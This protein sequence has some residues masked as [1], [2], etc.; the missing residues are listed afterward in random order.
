[1][2]IW[3]S[4]EQVMGHGAK[5]SLNFLSPDCVR[6]YNKSCRH[7]NLSAGY[8]LM[9]KARHIYVGIIFILAVTAAETRAVHLR[10]QILHVGFP[11]SG[12]NVNFTGADHHRL[13]CWTPILVELTNDEGDLFG[14]RI[15]VRQIDRDGDEIFDQRDVAVRGTKN[16]Y[17]YVPAG[18]LKDKNQ[19]CVRVFNSDGSLAELNN[20]RNEKVKELLPRRGINAVPEEAITILDISAQPINQLDKLVNDERLAQELIVAR[21][22]P[23]NVP[24][25]VAGLEMADIIIWD[26]ADPNSI[27]LHQQEALIEW[28]GRGG[29]LVVGVGKNWQVVNKSQIGK[30]LPAKLKE[31]VSTTKLR[32][33]ADTLFDYTDTDFDPPELETPLT[34]CPVTLETLTDDSESIIPSTPTMTDRLFVTGRPCGQGRVIMV[35]AELKDLFK[36]GT[37][38]QKFIRHILGLRLQSGAAEEGYGYNSVDLFRFIEGKIGF[39]VTAT[40]YLLIAFIFVSAYILI[41]TAGSW[42][43][44]K[45]KKLIQHNW[46]AFT[47]AAILASAFSLMAVQFIRGYG[48]RV[49]E[50]TIVDSR[51]GSY[52]ASATCYLGLKT[53]S[54]TLLD[55]RVPGNWTKSAE[56]DELIANLRPLAPISSLFETRTYVV[57]KQYESV[58]AL[59]E[60]RTVPIRAT[61]KQFEAH[62]HGEMNH[63][64]D[65]SLRRVRSD[66][67][68]L[69]GNSWIRNNLNTDLENCYLIVPGPNIKPNSPLRS[70]QMR[71]YK[72]GNIPNGAKLDLQTIIDKEISLNENWRPPFLGDSQKTWLAKF[73]HI[74]PQDRPRSE[75][76]SIRVKIEDVASALLLLT[77]FDTVDQSNQRTRGQEVGR[78][79]GHRLDRSSHLTKHTALFVGFSRDPSPARL[80]WRKPR[81]TSGGW[82]AI[83]PDESYVMYRIEMPIAGN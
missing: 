22:R 62:W 12:H 16:Y 15:E 42:T 75:D 43:L 20:D 4:S 82:K 70:N 14:G 6:V 56:S 53:G 31:A 29:T 68:Y 8:G 44:L 76:K 80:C 38:N 61:L 28:T 17:L 41:A 72:L 32:E 78:S 45:K 1:M 26:A 47:I 33:L 48:R 3:G 71:I 9:P 13:G 35:A 46:S 55:L 19:Y 74:R 81:K 5:P 64:C 7:D 77:T 54:H 34:Y 25:N 63:R 37:Q 2:G 10:G 83:H 23:Q 50:L 60:L 18:K 40:L 65:G 66:S 57:G 49:Q 69:H 79:Q 21:I 51:A 73:V 11:A 27:D 67:P 30:I 36:H 52:Q 24:D 58:A 39:Q 59:G